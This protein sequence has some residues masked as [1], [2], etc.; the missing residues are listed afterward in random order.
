MFIQ[1]NI[2]P[3]LKFHKLTHIKFHINPKITIKT[4]KATI[5]INTILKSNKNLYH[6]NNQNRL[7]FMSKT[8]SIYKGNEQLYTTHY[9]DSSPFKCYQRFI[10]TNDNRNSNSFKLKFSPYKTSKRTTK[11]YI[12][13]SDSII[14][15]LTP[16]TKLSPN[17]FPQRR[18]LN[19]SQTIRP[20][21]FRS[22]STTVEKIS[23]IEIE[24][25]ER[26]QQLVPLNP[27]SQ[28]LNPNPLLQKTSFF[29]T[30]RPVARTYRRFTKVHK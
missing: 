4:L 26:L 13:R 25:I 6:P 9:W 21:I 24:N 16:P 20:S 3:L 27:S 18:T 15:L 29:K 30:T 28:P 10:P 7:K 19:I 8:K 17:N 14:P 1:I 23:L 5:Y 12:P 11:S 2:I 22:R